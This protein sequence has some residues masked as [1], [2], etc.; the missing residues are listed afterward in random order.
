MTF[1]DTEMKKLGRSTRINTHN[2]K[3]LFRALKNVSNILQ[4]E[5][6][7]R[8]EEYKHTKHT[9]RYTHTHTH[10]RARAKACKEKVTLKS[11]SK[12]DSFGTTNASH[13]NTSSKKPA[14]SWWARSLI[15]YISII[16][17]FWKFFRLLFLLWTL[18]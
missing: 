7:F 10:A 6:A 18:S 12:A 3:S 13:M 1:S 11:K 14:L 5:G 4:T 17:C 15:S 16:I 2:T 8:V 9:Q